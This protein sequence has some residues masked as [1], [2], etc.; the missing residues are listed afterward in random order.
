M[1][2]RTLDRPW[3]V[4]VTLHEVPESGRRFELTADAATRAVIARSAGLRDL[5]RLQAAFDVSRR[6][7]NGLHVTGRVSA[8]VGQI[9]VVTLDSIESEVEEPVDLSFVAGAPPALEHAPGQGR[10]ME[11]IT[12]ESPEPLLNDTVD[13][14]ALATEF[15][16]LG[17]DPY[18]RKPGAV[19][20]PPPAGDESEHPF[21][22]LAKLKSGQGG[23]AK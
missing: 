22:A 12:T 17:V 21:A 10:Q 14:G 3:S 16:I 8:T 1:D 18:P 9:C 2:E 4:P 7:A 11:I 23:S 13:L 15:L 6:G 5:P 20:Q 19:F